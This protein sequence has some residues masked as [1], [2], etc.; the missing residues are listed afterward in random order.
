MMKDNDSLCNHPSETKS[1]TSSPS[2]RYFPALNDRREQA[3]A[4][5]RQQILDRFGQQQKR[6]QHRSPTAV[7][8]GFTQ[9]RSSCF[10][11]DEA[12]GLYSYS[13]G[14]QVE[15]M[16]G[17]YGCVEPF[18]RPRMAG[19]NDQEPTNSE[20]TKYVCFTIVFLYAME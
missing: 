9:S 20:N 18:Y 8:F 7:G 1:L 17:Q 12:A 3:L 19:P 11:V 14:N 16:G 6:L 5:Q 13:Y 2:S 4:N 10:D 15:Y